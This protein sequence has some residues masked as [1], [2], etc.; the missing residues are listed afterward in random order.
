MQNL[1]VKQ[2]GGGM[3]MIREQ[4]SCVLINITVFYCIMLFVILYKFVG[5]IYFLTFSNFLNFVWINQF[6]RLF[7]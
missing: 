2:N 7:N 3:V 1:Q 4:C 6:A 5:D